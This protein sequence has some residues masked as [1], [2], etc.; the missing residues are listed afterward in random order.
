MC[1]HALV[2]E[3][4]SVL[5]ALL[6]GAA[7]LAQAD[8]P[9]NDNFADRIVLT[10]TSITFTGTLAGA[11]VEWFGD[12]PDPCGWPFACVFGLSVWWEWT[13]PDSTAVTILL[14]SLGSNTF[15]ANVFAVYQSC[16]GFPTN[17]LNGCRSALS[18]MEFESDMPRQCLSFAAAKGVT[19]FLL[20]L[21]A[22][23]PPTGA[24]YRFTLA[25]TNAPMIL[26]QPRPQ[27]VSTNASALFTVLACGPPPLSYQWQFDGTDLPGE[28]NAMLALHAVSTN[29]EGSYSVVV[30]SGMAATVSDSA[31]LSVSRTD[32][33][34]ILRTPEVAASNGFSFILAGEAGRYYRIETSTNWADWSGEKGFPFQ[35]SPPYNFTSVMFNS[36]NTVLLSVTNDTDRKFVRAARYAPANEICNNNLR[37]LRFAKE[38]WVL[39]HHSFRSDTPLPVDIYPNYL[40]QELVCPDGGWYLFN[41]VDWPP[42]CTISNH[43][44][45]VPR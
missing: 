22:P 20:L 24:T 13:A 35:F 15:G 36:N 45:E 37:Q 18:G 23:P 4:R 32:V 1:S 16:E 34:P 31:D 38:L 9:P 17:Y 43:V 26:E 6:L 2:F 41:A 33:S 14:E 44:L 11:T 28:T 3:R 42:A 19:Y 30:S 39:E 25:A 27:T 40:P 8:P 29:D 12:V 7:C 21:D 5:V 10:G